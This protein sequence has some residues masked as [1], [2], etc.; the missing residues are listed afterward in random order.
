MA[1]GRESFAGAL[2]AEPWQVAP[3]SGG[4]YK[5]FTPFWRAVAARGVAAPVPAVADLPA[6]GHWPASE[7]LDDWAMA[8]AMQ[9]GAS[10]VRRW[11]QVGEAAVLA[12]LRRFLDGPVQGYALARDA[13]GLAGATSGL[14]EALAHGEIGPRMIWHAALRAG[15][16]GAAGAEAFRRELVWRDFAAHLMYHTPHLLTENWRAGWKDFP[17]RGDN[18]DAEAWRRGMT[19]EPIVDAAMREMYVTG[20][21]HN[22]ARMI[23][24]SYLTKH[25]LTDWRIGAAWFGQCLTDWD[26]ASNAMGWQW[27]AGSGP[28][29]APYFRIF[30]PAAQAAKFDAAGSY[31]RRW[32]AEEAASPS[33]EA[34]SYFAAVPSSWG[35]DP[36][37]RYPAP[38][39]ALAEGRARALAALAQRKA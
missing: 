1:L 36:G 7:V 32:I 2:L 33:P 24:A 3:G 8:A 9:R 15:E 37:Q 39:I 5:V 31:R 13:I 22:R 23:V 18:A 21:M 4:F 25:L 16:E 14:S 17:W 11:Q 29:A 34:L 28:D 27:V 26:A 38:R 35:L 30:N 20:R 10:V 6:P 19:G 12:Q